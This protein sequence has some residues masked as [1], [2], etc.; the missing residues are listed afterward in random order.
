MENLR[1][2]LGKT[3]TFGISLLSFGVVFTWSMFAYNIWVANKTDINIYAL[4]SGIV[5]A[6]LG[7]GITIGL[8][9]FILWKRN[10]R[11]NQTIT[12]IT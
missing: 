4:L 11:H 6:C 8:I 3:K 10:G 5:I 2:Q 9:L 1:L 12:R 7:I